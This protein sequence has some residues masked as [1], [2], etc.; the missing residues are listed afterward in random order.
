MIKFA[1]FKHENAPTKQKTSCA[2]NKM[3]YTFYDVAQQYN[4]GTTCTKRGYIAI[5]SLYSL[6]HPIIL[7]HSTVC[8]QYTQAHHRLTEKS[9]RIHSQYNFS[10]VLTTDL[11]LKGQK[12]NLRSTM[13][14]TFCVICIN[15]FQFVD[16][17]LVIIF[18]SNQ[19]V[20][21]RKGKNQFLI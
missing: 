5:G 13:E 18:A 16:F 7:L 4:K 19:N 12:R 10:D 1:I 9:A 21:N 6:S 17:R 20:T 14:T 8:V 11:K 2:A 15:S 3:F